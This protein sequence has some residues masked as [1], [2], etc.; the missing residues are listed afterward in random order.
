MSSPYLNAVTCTG[1][2]LSN[3]CCLIYGLQV[4][5][6]YHSFAATLLCQIRAW[7]LVCSFTL[8]L[9]PILAK[10]WRVNQIFKKAAFKRIVIKDLRL[11]IFIGANLSVDMIFMTFWQA[12]DPLK[13]RFIPIITKVSDIYI[14]LSLDL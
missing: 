4:Y 13:H 5:T 1:S 12:L 10:C 8:I 14:C 3:S 6:Q 2:M 9:V 11:F 7:F